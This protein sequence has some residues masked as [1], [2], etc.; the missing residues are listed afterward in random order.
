MWLIDNDVY[1]SGMG[2]TDVLD[3]I[4]MTFDDYE[5]YVNRTASLIQ[6]KVYKRCIHTS[7]VQNDYYVIQRNTSFKK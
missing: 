7:A 2:I 6:G 3:E 1:G 4:D 5:K